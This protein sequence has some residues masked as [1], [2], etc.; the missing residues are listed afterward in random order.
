MAMKAITLISSDDVAS[1]VMMS[2]DTAKV[3]AAVTV[4]DMVEATAAD[5]NG[6]Q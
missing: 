2:A 5:A 6:D 3:M 1:G 4:S